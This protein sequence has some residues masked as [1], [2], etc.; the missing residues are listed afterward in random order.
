M[1][2]AI[3]SVRSVASDLYAVLGVAQD[4]TPEEIKRSY[5][6]LVRELH[7]DL[8]PD[9]EVQDRFKQVTAAYEV[10]SDAEKR[11]MYDLGG[12]PRGGNGFG[13]GGM[14][15]GHIMDAF[16]GNSSR[17]PR[18]RVSR[19]KDALIRL[20]VDLVEATFGSTR[21][22]TVDTA[23]VCDECEGLGTAAGTTVIMCTMCQGRGE[24]QSVQRSFLGQVMTSRP[25]VQCQGY[26]SLIPHPCQ[27][28]GAEGRVRTRRTIAVKI[29]PGVSTGIR[30][31][32][33]GE[34]EVGPGGGPSGDLYL[35]IVEKAHEVFSREGD[36]LHC[37][38][39]LPMTA[40]ALGT[41][42]EL[43]TLDGV[44]NIDVRPGTHSGQTAT[45]RQ[46]GVTHLRNSG[47]G[48][49]HVH[50]EVVT[51]TK[52]DARQEELLRE[53]AALRGE[54]RPLATVQANGAS[55]SGFFSRLRDAFNS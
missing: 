27:E 14:G 41:T 30:I 8:N 47:R 37:T 40:A 32:L 29:P 39:T 5:R 36:D 44:E 54:E 21:E 22:I 19:G 1:H 18:P 28:C 25:C 13:G 26:G 4:A 10:L 15:F 43:E 46:K 11:Q 31:Q 6:K 12:D 23:V 16:F 48:D 53:F 35:E 49:L 42:V 2:V 3:L 9:P 34:G 17:G 20:Q 51:P 38:I 52:L 7:P 24:V 50:I 45:L 33:T 55:Q